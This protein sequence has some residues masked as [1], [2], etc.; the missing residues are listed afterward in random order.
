MENNN[1]TF[2]GYPVTL[3]KVADDVLV[4]CKDVI[5]TFSQAKSFK[6]K[7]RWPANY[8][9]FGTK[10]SSPAEITEMPNGEI[11]IACLQAPRHEF[12]SLYKECEN[13]LNS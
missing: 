10:T 2:A 8:Y 1:L 5:G 11:K 7:S 12:D 4:H 6:E 3:R 13:L 9:P